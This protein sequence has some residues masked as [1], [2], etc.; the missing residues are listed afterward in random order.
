M[1]YGICGSELLWFKSYLSNRKQFVTIDNF[2]S[3][4]TD[5]LLGVPQGSILGPL[6]FLIYI[7]D[8][9]LASKLFALLFADDTTLNHYA[10]LLIL[11]SKKFVIFSDQT[12]SCSIVTKPKCNF[13]ATFSKGEGVKI[14]CNNNKDL[15]LDP[16]LIKQISLVNSTDEIPAVKFLGIF[17]DSTTF[18]LNIIPPLS[19]KKLS[20]ALYTLCMA[21]N[22]LSS[23]NLKLIYYSTFHCHLIYAIQIWSCCP[24]ANINELFKLQKT[25]VRT[26][27]NAKYN[28]HTE[29][30][31]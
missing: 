21:K 14:F 13:F 18:L 5:V 15:L 30:L 6:L 31:F 10:H 20:K 25:A 11:N 24:T 23:K 9:P 12:N 2:N 8:L 27:C 22:I 1:K 29:P 17:I 26:H 28:A 3:L 7:N 19:A 16:S 4:L